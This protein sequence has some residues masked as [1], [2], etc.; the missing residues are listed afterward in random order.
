MSFRFRSSLAACLVLPLFLAGCADA[1]REAALE[2][3]LRESREAIE[4]EEQAIAALRREVAQIEA[5][6]AQVESQRPPLVASWVALRAD[7]PYMS[8]CI[9]DDL[10]AKALQTTFA[11]Q[12]ESERSAGWMALGTCLVLAMRSDYDS[13]KR[14]FK[15]LMEGLTSLNEQIES[16]KIERTQRRAQLEQAQT[17]QRSS[18]LKE[19]IERLSAALACERRLACRAR[20]FFGID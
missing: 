17:S 14:R 15:E 19:D 2:A 9:V 18:Q 6:L 16:L 3:A 10:G 1:G 13:T 8:A 7:S 11:G 12:T 5:R 20:R 4:Q